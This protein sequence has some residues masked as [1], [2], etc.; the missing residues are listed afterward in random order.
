ME[1]LSARDKKT[2]LIWILCAL[3]GGGVA[4]KYFFRAFPEASIDF[5]VSRPAAAG[6]ARQFVASEGGNLAHYRSSIVFDVDDTAKTY[7]ERELGLQQANQLMSTQVHTW[8]WSVRFFRPLQPEEFGVDLDPAGEIVGYTHKVADE[9]QGARL[10][11]SAARAKAEA[12]LRD[13]LHKDLSTYDYLPEEA[14]S[15]EYTNRREWIFTW[16]RRG[17]RAKDAPYRMKVSVEGDWIG[18]YAESLKVPDAWKRDFDRLRSKN[19]FLETI[20]LLPYGLLLG[21]CLWVIIALGREGVLK[22]K[23]GLIVG[24][25]LAEL[26]FLMTL[27]D[28]PSTLAGYDTTSSYP[29]FVLTQIAVA[30]A[31]AVATALLVVLAIVPG[32]PLYRAGQPER[33][34]LRYFCR[35]PGIRTRE[36][37]RSCAIGVCMAAAHIGYLVVFY[38]V[39]RKFGAW[40]PQDIQY[41][42]VVSTV[43]PWIFPLTIGLYAAASEEFLFRLFA[44]HFLQRV[45][46]SRFLAVVIPAFAWSFLHSNY[47]QEPPYIRG[48]EIGLIGIVAGLVMLRWGILTTLVWHYTVDAGLISMLL[49]RSSS[50]YF[51]VSGAVVGA[52]ALIPLAIAGVLY[53]ARGGFEPAE[54]ML[55]GVATAEETKEAASA[56]IAVETQPG[57]KGE[58]TAAEPAAIAGERR[59]YEALTPQKLGILAVCA[60]IGAG[61]IWRV[62]TH[63]VGDFVRFSI[64]AQQ[65]ETRADQVLRDWKI[66]PASYRRAATTTFSFDPFANEYLRRAVGID[67]TNQIYKERVPL[68]YWAVRYFRDSQKEE[69]LVVLLPDGELHSVHHTLVEDAP[70]ANLTKEDAQARAET[71]LRE[72]KHLDLSQWRVVEAQSTKEKN[73]TDHDFEWEQIAPLATAPGASEPAHVRVHLQVQGDEVSG[74]RIFVQVPEDWVRKETEST[75]AGTAQFVGFIGLLA[76]LA[77]TVL[78]IFFRNLKHPEMAAVTWRRVAKWTVWVLIAAAVR[79]INLSPLYMSR[80]QTELPLKIYFGTVAIGLTLGSVLLYTVTFFILG[81]AWFF[82]A[83]AFGRERLPGWSGMRA[84]YYRDAFCIA[85]LGGTAFIGMGRLPELMSRWPMVQ[86]SL[87]AE[88]PSGLDARWPWLSAVASAV[89]LGFL[90]TALLALAAGFLADRVR[91]VWLRATLIVALAALMS[92]G[93]A[94]SGSFARGTA[95]LLL[96]FALVWLG[97]TRL[98]RF[99]LLGYFLLVMLLTLAEG[100]A[101]LLRQPNSFFHSNGYAVAAFAVALLAWPVVAWQRASG[102]AAK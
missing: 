4:Y 47:P 45:T 84:A 99:N 70:G 67:G 73:R 21:A 75:L 12:F 97:V 89:I 82:L 23:G 19:D 94:T 90:L 8:Y 100:G 3:I 7:L 27:N 101:E 13:T 68:A 46:K 72:Q 28:W 26:F 98:A 41:D 102:Q 6:L 92:S 1:R 43:A 64:D 2:L 56:E 40:A 24:A 74:Y 57:T 63:D 79:F 30:A 17:F 10:D 80:Y 14:S 33:V 96:T 69:Y 37:F 55:N 48:I 9:A 18:E 81:L 54:T 32:E 62:R 29:S 31:G 88:V 25:V 95:L 44:I 76:G 50:L 65:A 58:A 35:L 83:R 85:L 52:G 5:R 11:Q 60:L 87:S 77:V 39:V 34:R 78:V 71:Y 86:H 51:R 42:N 16:E 36:F 20:A 61:L 59:F 49:L 53:L 66:D 91:N 93:Y 15:K 38:I 22:W